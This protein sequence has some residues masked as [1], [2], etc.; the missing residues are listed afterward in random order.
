MTSGL[1]WMEIP[2]QDLEHSKFNRHY[3]V[4]CSHNDYLTACNNEVP[5]RWLQTYK[6]IQK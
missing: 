4:P 6:K 3:I 5:E 2:L 1:W